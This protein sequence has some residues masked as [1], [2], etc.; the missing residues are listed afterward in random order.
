MASE[1]QHVEVVVVLRPGADVRTVAEWLAEH[2]LRVVTLVAGV[3]A[4]GD[5]AAV[6]AVFGAEHLDRLNVPGELHEHVESVAVVPPK[7]FHDGA[8]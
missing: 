3:L 7:Q 5:A 1:R 4:S 8:H 6:K 2:G